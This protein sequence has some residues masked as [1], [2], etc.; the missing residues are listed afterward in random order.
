MDITRHNLPEI[1]APAGNPERLQTA[2]TYG[3]DA[4]YLG[5]PELNLRAQSQGFDWEELDLALDRAHTAG[6]KI[7]FCLN[8]FPVE[9]QL[10]V[11]EDY[12]QKL[13][14]RPLDGLIV[15][16]PGLVA[17][18]RRTVP[19]IPIHLSTQANTTN[20]ASVNFWKDMGVKRVN[21]ARELNLRQIR[22]IRDHAPDT[23][24][25]SFVHGAMCMAISGRCLLSSYLNQR[26]A[27][28][29]WCTHPCRY[30]Y[31]V[32]SLGLEERKRPGKTIWETRQ[33]AEYSDI[34]ASEDLCLIKYLG[35][36]VN[37]NINALK[38]EGR[39]K[40]SSYL[41]QVV[42]IYKTALQDLSQNRFRP[43]L[44]FSEL[45]HTSSRPLGTGFFLPTGRRTLLQPAKDKMPTPVLAKLLY[46]ESED[47]WLISVRHRFEQ[48]SGFRIL[49]PGLQR[50]QLKAGEFA[51]ENLEGERVNTLHSGLQ[52]KLRSDRPEL[53]PGIL[54]RKE[55]A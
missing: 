4:V 29:G 54:L 10:P 24:L 48:K 7:Y 37:N 28:Q 55:P 1:L 38:I 34:L 27:N 33:E 19:Q 52:G 47:S 2:L 22:K 26:S 36:F 23:E 3:A 39:M 32:V 17:L 51:L 15:A 35:W 40:T 31:R 50:P 16:D 53:K 25:E 13:E 8:I 45:G 9:E 12:L 42:D 18:A 30:D 21:L 5:G 46:Q 41:A 11:T 20:S 14:Q 6:K 49:L 43:G 44:Y